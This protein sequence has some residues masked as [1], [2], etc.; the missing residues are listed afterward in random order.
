V[1]NEMKLM[2]IIISLC[3]DLRDKHDTV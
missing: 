3:I 2:K 1:E